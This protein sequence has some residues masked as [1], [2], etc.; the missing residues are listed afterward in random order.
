MYGLAYCNHQIRVMKGRLIKWTVNKIAEYR[1]DSFKSSFNPVWLN[2]IPSNVNFTVVSFSGKKQFLDQLFSIA[3]FYRNIGKPESWTIYNDGTYT[4]E[5]LDI[6]HRIERICIKE[7]SSFRKELPEASLK[8]FPTLQKIEILKNISPNSPVIFTDS[9]ILFYK[10]LRRYEKMLEQHNWYIADEG[11]SYFD[12][13]YIANN[14]TDMEPL[15][16]GFM[17]LNSKPKWGPVLDYIVGKFNEGRLSYWTDQTACH[18]MAQNEKFKVLSKEEF[19]VGGNDSFKFK[20]ASDYN[21]IALRHFVGP[22]RHKMW[23]YSWKKVLEI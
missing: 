21:R 22:V 19:V 5:E 20:S 7:I 15:N 13:D 3:S 17:V 11:F 23:Q 8:K 12:T 16:L 1:K 4:D 10:G 9:D 2:S 18:I 6:F 14:A